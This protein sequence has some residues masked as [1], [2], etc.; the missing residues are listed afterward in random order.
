[1]FLMFL[2]ALDLK[3]IAGYTMSL[4]PQKDVQESG[5]K[6]EKRSTPDLLSYVRRSPVSLSGCC[7][8]SKTKYLSDIIS[9]YSYMPCVLFNI[10][11][12]VVN[13][14]LTTH[15]PI[16]PK[17][18]SSVSKLPFLSKILEKAPD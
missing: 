14:P 17:T 4:G 7:S 6:M 3:L 16:S 5:K 11:N 18:I 9:N 15:S 13:P 8:K 10:I 12:S 1:M 2:S